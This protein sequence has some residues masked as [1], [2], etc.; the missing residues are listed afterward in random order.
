MELHRG[1]LI[2]RVPVEGAGGLIFAVGMMAVTLMAM[3]EVRMLALVSLVGGA[4]L[5]PILIRMHR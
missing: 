2:S 4:A 5:A 1:I 3:P